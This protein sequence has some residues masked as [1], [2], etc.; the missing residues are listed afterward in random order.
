LSSHPLLGYNNY[1]MRLRP[2]TLLLLFLL[3]LFAF[4]LALMGQIPLSQDEAYYWCWSRKLAPSYYDAPG[5]IA[6]IHRLVSLFL[7]QASPFTVRL[8]AAILGFLT[9]WILYRAYRVFHDDETEAVALVMALSILPIS[10]IGSF[11]SIYDNPLIFFLALGYLFMLKLL[12]Q[13]RPYLWYL[14][15]LTLTAGL[16]CKISALM[17]AGCFVLFVLLSPTLRR[18]LRR[19]HPYLATLLAVILLIPFL[20]WNSRHDW[21]TVLAVSRITNAGEITLLD[22]LSFAGDFLFSQL[23]AYSPLICISLVAALILAVRRYF[24]TREESLLLLLMLSVPI[25]AYFLLQSFRSRVLGNWPVVG[26]VPALM[27]TARLAAASGAPSADF[28]GTAAPSRKPIYFRRSYL[29]AGL[30]LSLLL[31]LGPVIQARS[32][33]A[34]PLLRQIEKALRLDYR[35]DYR[36][37]QELWGWTELAG[38]VEQHRAGADFILA[39]KYQIAA[40]L[41]FYLPDHPQVLV[42][43]SGLRRSQFDLWTDLSRRQGQTAIFVDDHRIPPE[44]AAQFDRVLPREAPLRIMDQGEP[45]KR[46]FIYRAE[47]FHPR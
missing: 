35:I 7:P 25:L 23:A 45:L 30:A 38:A 43:S 16:Y 46:F 11:I 27:L 32:Y 20:V 37:D 18:E 4:H 33:L 19:P 1:P 29:A 28:R 42:Y 47:G 8:P 39:R 10:F 40:E 31:S 41:E 34:S 36:L 2:Q 5:M 12:R 24:Q 21:A 3:A 44:L 14:L 22:R 6:W 15:S 13:P 17:P 9:A 26:F